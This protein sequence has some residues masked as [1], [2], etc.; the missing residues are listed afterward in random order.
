MK[1]RVQDGTKFKPNSTFAGTFD[2]T[3]KNK[4]YFVLED[5]INEGTV[6]T[7]GTL[8]IPSGAVLT[9]N[10]KTGTVKIRFGTDLINNN[11]GTKHVATVTGNRT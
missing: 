6:A 3:N 1:A 2:T 8:N 11:Y 5:P 10:S 7:W 9:S 4:N